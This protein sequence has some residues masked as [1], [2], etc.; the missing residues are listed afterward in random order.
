MST[1]HSP[2]TTK[3]TIAT[4]IH[5]YGNTQDQDLHADFNVHDGLAT[6]VQVH[7]RKL[8]KSRALSVTTI[9]RDISQSPESDELLDVLPELESELLSHP[10]SHSS[11]PSLWG[12]LFVFLN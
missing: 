7:A 11:S 3:Q 10:L 9:D 4:L 12:S 2:E 8:A 5:Y 6:W 1:N